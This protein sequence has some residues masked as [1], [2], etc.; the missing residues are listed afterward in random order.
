M[1]YAHDIFLSYHRADPVHGWVRNH[2][3][4]RLR[5]WLATELGRD[6]SIFVDEEAIADGE[7]WPERL[8]LALRDSRLLVPIWEP[9]YFHRPWCKA[10]LQCMRWREQQHGLRTVEQP[11]GL[12]LPVLF[13]DGDRFVEWLQLCQHRDLRKYSFPERSFEQTR[14]AVKL[15]TEVKSFV[16]NIRAALDHVPPWSESLPPL[17]EQVWPDDRRPSLPRFL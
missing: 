2:F 6:V 11:S 1:S 4:H 7:G 13:H 8:Q 10:E 9:S 14:G 16:Q 17:V 12:I 5:S 3:L 15:T